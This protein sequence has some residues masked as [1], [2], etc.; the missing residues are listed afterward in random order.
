MASPEPRLTTLKGTAVATSFL[1][2]LSRAFTEAATVNKSITIMGIA[3]A[4]EAIAWLT[5]HME[6]A[7]PREP[8]IAAG[9]QEARSGP[10][11]I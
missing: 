5:I 10:S 9:I 8:S 6:P 3:T 7:T 4:L 1:R 11:G 2:V